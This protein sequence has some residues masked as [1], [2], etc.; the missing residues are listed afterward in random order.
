MATTYKSLSTNDIVT[1]KTLLHEAIPITGTIVTGTYGA[2]GAE[3]NIKNYTHGM[4]QSVYDYPFLSSSANHIFD[5]TVGMHAT[6][7]LSSSTNTQQAKKQNIYNQMAQV[8]MGYDE[9]GNIRLFDED[10]DLSGGTKMRSVFFMNFARL[11][12]KDEIK[13]GSF[14]IEIGVNRE[15]TASNSPNKF[16]VQLADTNAQNDYRVNSPAGDY[17]ILYATEASGTQVLKVDDG[18]QKAG[19]IFYQ[20][21]IV[22][23]TGSL[24]S[25][26]SFT[27]GLLG[28]DCDHPRMDLDFGLRTTMASSSIS[29][30]CDAF[31]RRIYN[32]QF[33]N[34]TELNSTVYFC[35]AH[36]NEFNYSTNPTYLSSSK[37]VVKNVAS[38]SPV[39]YISTVGLYSSDNELLAV[40]KLSEPLKK[41]PSNELTLRVRLDY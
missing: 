14:A 15:H 28:N 36:H 38:D 35:R 39:S 25:S 10:G 37:M 12:T 27:G 8:L 32:V 3:K 17:G 30:S 19:L 5:M 4:F 34:T 7:G 23:I 40:A 9:N 24:F 18:T 16:R 1:T 21:G 41:D 13:K 6:S 22:V 26:G 29:A 31:R 33:N 11:L 20:A 2:A